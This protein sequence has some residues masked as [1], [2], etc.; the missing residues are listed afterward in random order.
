MRFPRSFLRVWQRALL[1][2]PGLFPLLPLLAVLLGTPPSLPEPG[3][4]WA[5][6]SVTPA[7]P[8]LRPAPAPGVPVPLA[9]GEPPRPFRLP[10]VRPA[11]AP[12]VPVWAAPSRRVSLSELGRRQA[13]GG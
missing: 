13:D 5:A 1:G 7:L 3:V 4:R 11:L 8:E 9:A 2:W 12:W 10:D 6:G